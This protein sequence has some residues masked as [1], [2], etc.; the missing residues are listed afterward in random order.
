MSGSAPSRRRG[1]CGPPRAEKPLKFKFTE[2]GKAKVTVKPVVVEK[3]VPRRVWAQP[4]KL[5]VITD[6]VC[7]VCVHSQSP[8]NL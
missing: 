3:K 2:E 7:P 1:S 8:R 4:G 5:D 6:Q